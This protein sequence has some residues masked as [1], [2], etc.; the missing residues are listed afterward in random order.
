MTKKLCLS[1]LLGISFIAITIFVS[2]QE[3]SPYGLAVSKEHE[4]LPLKAEGQLPLWLE[5]TLIRNSAIPILQN[6][7]PAVHLFDG[8]AM[9]HRF[10][11]HR[12]NIKYSNRFLR[13]KEYDSVV[14]RGVIDYRSFAGAP[15]NKDTAPVSESKLVKNASVNVFRY[16]EDYVALT[17]VPLPARFDLLTLDTLGS[18]QFKDALPKE[19]CWESAHPHRD[20][21]TG[22]IFNFL[23][24]FGQKSYY[25]LYRIKEGS[26]SREMLS[27]IPVELPS[28]MHSFAM[29]EHFLI[30][31][32]FPFLLN[33]H[34]LLT[35]GK[36]FI[37]NFQWLPERGTRFLV[38]DKSSGKIVYDIISEP[39]FSFHHANAYEKDGEIMI[40]LMAYSS[41]ALHPDIFPQATR[42]PNKGTEWSRL[43]R[44]R[45]N[46]QN[47]GLIASTLLE[48]EGEYPRIDDRLDGKPYRYLYMTTKNGV[49][50][51]DLQTGDL[52]K[53]QQ[54]NATAMEPVFVPEPH[55]KEE[56]TGVILTIV[57]E[58]ENAY[59][60]IL[61]A[62]T[63]IEMARAELPH[64]IPGS[65]HGQ[66]FD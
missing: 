64:L 34:D 19:K 38:I 49:A 5:G 40:D 8:L 53:W 52:T 30:L 15:K 25:V 7:K 11:L 39:I 13:S 3:H 65:F 29:T 18:F 20:S 16:A 6:G 41:I 4:N 26:S 42:L 43:M 54:K 58:N 1:F 31:T 17:E 66:F 56:D 44:Y 33:P 27:K 50:K 48:E 45:L 21:V 28:Y 10:A 9:L 24:E 57:E 32:E 14:K 22:T 47:S 46:L 59:L 35:S 60:L 51:L 12:G 62:K 2:R 61:D 37:D 63:L 36:P 55:S 23:I